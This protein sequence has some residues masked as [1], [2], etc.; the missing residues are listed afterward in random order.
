MTKI[1]LT[2]ALSIV[3]NLHVQARLPS[4]DCNELKKRAENSCAESVVKATCADLKSCQGYREKCPQSKESFTGCEGMSSCLETDAKS[5]NSRRYC[6]YGWSGQ[7]NDGSCYLKNNTS[8]SF[9]NKC[10]GFST[11]IDTHIDRDFN[12]EGHRQRTI[13]KMISCKNA[14]D[15][16]DAHCT[17]SSLTVSQKDAE[18]KETSF[19]LNLPDSEIAPVI[20]QSGSRETGVAPMKEQPSSGTFN[21]P[22]GTSSDR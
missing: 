9:T 6:M 3:L 17:A 22:F 8:R 7:P 20:S 2:F 19:S 12:C 13:S 21:L 16:Y 15:D 5:R 11:G 14:I 18:C 10:P 1:I 4:T